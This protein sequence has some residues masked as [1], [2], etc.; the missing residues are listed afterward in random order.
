MC[1]FANL[2]FLTFAT[3]ACTLTG[4]LDRGPSPVAAP[5]WDVE[6]ITDKAM[7]QCD[8]DSDG[9]LTKTELKNAPGLEY[10]FRQLDT[11]RD[12][13]LSRD[14]VRQRFQDYLDSKMGIQGFSCYVLLKN[15]RPLRDGHVRL[16]PEPFLEG[17]I[18]VAEGDVVHDRMGLAEVS[19]TNDEGLVGVRSGMYRV[20]ITSPSF[21]VGK[22]YNEETV[23]GVEISPF[24]NAYEDPGG[25]KFRV[26]K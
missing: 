11:D 25:I 8:V 18:E 1:K 13:K 4:C 15:G 16:I 26:G 2:L 6:G 10:A 5:A 14:E 7:E 20:E 3:M 9:L 23:L 21:K 17:I 22:K 12:K 24:A 19:M